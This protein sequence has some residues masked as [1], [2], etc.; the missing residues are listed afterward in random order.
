M[1]KCPESRWE[2]E[3]LSVRAI[4]HFSASGQLYFGMHAL[5]PLMALEQGLAQYIIDA[6]L[7]YCSNVLRAEGQAS[8]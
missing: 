2:N 1:L 5:L 3:Q 4:E 6:C 7:L 8:I